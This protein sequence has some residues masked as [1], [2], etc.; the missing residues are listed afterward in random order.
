VPGFLLSGRPT[1]A[2]DGGAMNMKFSGVDPGLRLGGH[3]GCCNRQALVG[4]AGRSA[5]S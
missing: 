1:V 4:P 2:S 5:T 3:V